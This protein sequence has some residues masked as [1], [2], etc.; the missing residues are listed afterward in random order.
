MVYIARFFP[1][2]LSVFVSKHRLHA[3]FFSVFLDVA[4]FDVLCNDPWDS[5]GLLLPVL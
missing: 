3:G 5:Y 2:R 4:Y 1:L